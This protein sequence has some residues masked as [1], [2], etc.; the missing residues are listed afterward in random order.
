LEWITYAEKIGTDLIPEVFE[1]IR[2]LN[3]IGHQINSIVNDYEHAYGG[4]NKMLT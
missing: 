3:T 2:R 4:I 1:N